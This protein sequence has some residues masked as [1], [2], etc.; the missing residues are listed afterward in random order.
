MSEVQAET[1]V[2]LLKV[3]VMLIQFLPK[4]YVLT[5]YTHE[6]N[7]IFLGRQLC[8]SVKILRFWERESVPETLENFYTLVWLSAQDDFIKFCRHKSFETFTPEYQVSQ[9]Y[10]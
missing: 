2:A 6:F 3:P 8:Q 10:V 4:L 5:E 9:K 1:H 7:K